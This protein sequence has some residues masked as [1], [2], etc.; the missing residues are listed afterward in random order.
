[1]LLYLNGAGEGVQGGAT[2]PLDSGGQSVD[3]TPRRGTA[4]FFRHGF[5]PG[6][7][8]HT[9]C[10][11]RGLVPKSVARINLMYDDSMSVTELS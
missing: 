11:V 4:L 6:S 10:T 3:V 7:V 5:Q 8:R 1:M 9:G 2:R